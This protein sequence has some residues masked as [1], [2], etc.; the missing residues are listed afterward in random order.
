MWRTLLCSDNMAWNY[1]TNTTANVCLLE[2]TKNK[3]HYKYGRYFM[4][5]I[6]AVRLKNC[7]HD[8]RYRGLTL[9]QHPIMGENGKQIVIDDVKTDFPDWCPLEEV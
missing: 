4:R 6:P 8:C 7:G 9:C 1:T 2:S 3:N 5:I